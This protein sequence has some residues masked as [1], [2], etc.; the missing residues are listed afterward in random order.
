MGEFQT[1][2]GNPCLTMLADF[3]IEHIGRKPETPECLVRNQIPPGPT[4]ILLENRDVH[5][6]T[7]ASH[8]QRSA[9]QDLRRCRRCRLPFFPSR[10]APLGKRRGKY[11]LDCRQRHVFS[12]QIATG[13]FSSMAATAGRQARKA[14]SANPSQDSR[15]KHWIPDSPC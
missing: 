10:A 9:M 14:R 4:P 12:R 15:K 8:W 5:I 13:F 11:P 3:F 7:A 6:P 2:V 1:Q